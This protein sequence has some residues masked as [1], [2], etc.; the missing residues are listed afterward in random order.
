VFG[1]AGRALGYRATYD[2]HLEES[3]RRDEDAGEAPDVRGV[4]PR[5]AR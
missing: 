2:R 3:F 1:T 4:H 5:S